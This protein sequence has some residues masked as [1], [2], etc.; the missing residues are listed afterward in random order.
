MVQEFGWNLFRTAAQAQLALEKAESCCLKTNTEVT[1]I[2]DVRNRNLDYNWE[3]CTKDS[4]YNVKYLVNSCG[5]RTG[6]ID[7]LLNQ[8]SAHSIE[9]AYIAK[10]PI[11][12]SRTHFSWR[13]LSWH[14]KSLAKI[15]SDHG[16][17]NIVFVRKWS[18]TL[19]NKEVGG[20]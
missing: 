5:F 17:T 2:R 10:Q 9:G 11:D 8:H 3:I 15:I 7:A 14:V 1:N 20:I 19:K 13:T 6:F 4:V 18:D 12:N 16:M